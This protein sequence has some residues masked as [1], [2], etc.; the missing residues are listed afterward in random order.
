MYSFSLEK[1]TLSGQVTLNKENEEL[2][3][4]LSDMHKLFEL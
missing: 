4:I 2:I 1:I 3:V